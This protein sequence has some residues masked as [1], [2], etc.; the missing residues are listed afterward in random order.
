MILFAGPKHSGKTTAVGRIVERLRNEGF[1]VAGVLAPALYEEGVLAGFDVLDLS[2]GRRMRGLRRVEHG[3]SADVG[4]FAFDDEALDLGQAALA[5]EAA[6]RAD[7]VVVDEFGPLERGG[8]G[9][10]VGVDNLARSAA[11]ML[12]LVVREEIA[13]LVRE[14]YPSLVKTVILSRRPDAAEAIIALLKSR[15]PDRHT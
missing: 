6:F 1:A 7:L 9:W 4:Q 13:N 8:G 15:H 11:G 2:T 14:L 10:R 3:K 12:M 5:D